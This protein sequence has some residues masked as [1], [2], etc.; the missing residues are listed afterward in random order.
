M[1]FIFYFSRAVP[2]HQRGSSINDMGV[3]DI[4]QR[5]CALTS[6]AHI[7]NITVTRRL[8]SEGVNVPEYFRINKSLL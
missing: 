7:V 6:V 2:D 4:S 1:Y 3:N 5:A 8:I